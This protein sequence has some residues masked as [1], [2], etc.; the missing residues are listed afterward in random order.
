MP[1]RRSRDWV[2]T[3]LRQTQEV[4]ICGWIPGEGRR[5]G[6]L[7]ALLLSVQNEHGQLIYAGH[8]GTGFTDQALDE[9]RDRLVSLVRQAS[10]FVVL[11]PR[12]FAR[13]AAGSNPSSSARSSTG[14]GPATTGS[15]IHLGVV[16]A[17]TPTRNR[18]DAPADTPRLRGHH[19]SSRRL[20]TR[21]SNRRS[22]SL[23]AH[24]I[25]VSAG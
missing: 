19:L 12:E 3:P 22:T 13:H 5:A 15:G 7:G 8:V 23:A 1:G 20:V 10:P 14:S 18:F 9:T 4:I 25:R 24:G 11:V 6:T 2:K 17:R 16:S 21:F